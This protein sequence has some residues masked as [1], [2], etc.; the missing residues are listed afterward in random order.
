MKADWALAAT[1]GRNIRLTAPWML[2]RARGL[3]GR[4]GGV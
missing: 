3:Q 1:E 2:E 4:G